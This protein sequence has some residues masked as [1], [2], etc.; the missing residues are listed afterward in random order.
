[1]AVLLKRDKDLPMSD[2]HDD[3]L[4][5]IME[6][7][8]TELAEA[9]F[10]YVFADLESEAKK[11]SPPRGFADA[12]KKAHTQK[13]VALIAELKKA[14]PSRGLIRADF[15]PAELARAYEQGGA[16]CLSVLTDRAFFQG[17]A[18]HLTQAR[19]AT[20][21][22]VLR[23]DF[24]YDPYQVVEARALGAD[25][26]LLIMSVITDAQAKELRGVADDYGMDVLYEVHSR[27]EI[28][29]TLPLN[30]KL[31]GINN[32][33]LRT[34]DTSLDTTRTLLRDLPSETS[35]DILWV[36]ESGI[37]SGEQIRQLQAI[38]AGAFLVG[39]ALMA[40]PDVAAATKKLLALPA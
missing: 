13:R 29:R 26:I 15:K 24:I 16:T 33:Y 4:A 14:S 23:K 37:E 12:L 18:T 27:D 20:A 30:P 40:Q 1:M 36:S 2:K 11:A 22:P 21:L 35:G 34:F 6:H 31:V 8:K 25:A 28:E 10:R 32:R 9:K 5:K 17:E 39:H 3:F 38:G 19:E 7:K